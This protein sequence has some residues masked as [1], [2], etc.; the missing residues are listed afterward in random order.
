MRTNLKNNYRWVVITMLILLPLLS[1]L[2]IYNF[3]PQLTARAIFPLL[4]VWAWL[5][6]W[7]HYV[8]WWFEKRNKSIKPSQ[9]YNQISMQLVL[10]LILLHPGL[11]AWEQYRLFGLLPPDSFT[12]YVAPEL[13]VFVSMGSLALLLF[14]VYEVTQRLRNSD[15]FKRQRGW[16]SISQAV[17]MTLVFIHGI[18]IGDTVLHSW[19]L[20]IWVFLGVMLTP[21]LLLAIRESS[22]EAKK[23]TIEQPAREP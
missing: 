16:V 13:Q 20:G 11:L 15:W 2:N 14:L 23:S 9:K 10:V 4:G 1:W 3:Q 19:M 21:L 8:F 5:I 7:T 12:L 22:W 6:M 18:M 17:A